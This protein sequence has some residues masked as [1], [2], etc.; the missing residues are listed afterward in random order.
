MPSACFD[1]YHLL[2]VY[3]GHDL[4]TVRDICVRALL[5]RGMGL[6]MFN[7]AINSQTVLFTRA[8]YVIGPTDRFKDLISN[9]RS[10]DPL[11]VIETDLILTAAFISTPPPVLFLMSSSIWP[12]LYSRRC[13]A[14]YHRK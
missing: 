6:L 10:R 8:D 1:Q 9:D 11:Q 7:W 12:L 14:I 4:L 2:S 3:V 13:R 5:Q